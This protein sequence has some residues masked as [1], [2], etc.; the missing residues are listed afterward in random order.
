MSDDLQISPALV[1]SIRAELGNG[2]QSLEDSSSS[3]PTSIDAG[4]IT[5]MLCTILALMA[6]QAAMVSASL[7]AIG[8]QVGEA[9]AAFWQTDA[10]VA[11]DYSGAGGAR[12]AD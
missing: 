8:D 3:A 7:G 12:R 9:G 11:A 2:R 1:E 5:E 10:E 6:E 4:E